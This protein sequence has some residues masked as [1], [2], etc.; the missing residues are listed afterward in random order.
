MLTSVFP[1]TR[2]SLIAR[3][4]EQPEAVREVVEIYA[5]AVARYL[6]MKFPREHGAGRLDDV[7]QEVL[8]ALIEKPEVL[9]RARRGD[10]SRFRYLLMRVAHNAARNAVRRLA[11]RHLVVS[12]TVAEWADDAET[13]ATPDPGMDQAWA[14]SLIDIAW[15]ELRAWV[16]EGVV[17]AD[18]LI[19]A[20]THLLHGAHLRDIAADQGIG[21]GTCHRRLA[22]ARHLLRRSIIDHLRATGEIGADEDE[23]TACDAILDGARS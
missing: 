14:R 22:R 16:R 3:L 10:G 12:Q 5:D 9:A 4:T 11:D 18:C 2:W 7:V 6:V 21:L 19:V 13:L 17:P 23:E 15:D 20:E 8:L 1:A